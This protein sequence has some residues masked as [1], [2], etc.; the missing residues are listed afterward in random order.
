MWLCDLEMLFLVEKV[1]LG[2]TRWCILVKFSNL[3]WRLFLWQLLGHHLMSNG[4]NEEKQVL[5][6]NQLW[7]AGLYL[8]FILL[9]CEFECAKPTEIWLTAPRAAGRNRDVLIPHDILFS[10]FCLEQENMTTL[11]LLNIF[12]SISFSTLTLLC[13]YLSGLQCFHAIM[14]SPQSSCVKHTHM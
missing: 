13:L 10:R 11:I 12:L 7:T 3:F 14:E 8:V 9:C 4:E 1:Y 6:Q 5:K 2:T